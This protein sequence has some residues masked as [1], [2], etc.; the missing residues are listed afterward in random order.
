VG[1]RQSKH[2]PAHFVAD[3]DVPTNFETVQSFEHAT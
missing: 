1:V 3:V 2:E